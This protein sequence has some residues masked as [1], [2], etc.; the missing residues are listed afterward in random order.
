M[1]T[2]GHI[3]EVV[4]QV[5]EGTLASACSTQTTKT[6]KRSLQ[7]NNESRKVATKSARLRPKPPGSKSSM[8]PRVDARYSRMMTVSANRSIA[9]CPDG[10]SQTGNRDLIDALLRSCG[11]GTNP[12]PPQTLSSIVPRVACRQARGGVMLTIETI[13]ANLQK[14]FSEYARGRMDVLWA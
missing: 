12:D 10:L 3:V 13:N 1:L 2:N 8:K 7:D 4:N 14:G 9:Y 5:L 6:E 11:G